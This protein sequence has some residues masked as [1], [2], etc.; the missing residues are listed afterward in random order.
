MFYTIWYEL[1]IVLVIIVIAF[2]LF[3]VFL[4]P[5]LPKLIKLIKPYCIKMWSVIYGNNFVL[6]C[7]FISVLILLIASFFAPNFITPYSLEHQLSSNLATT[8]NGLMSPLIAI[9]AAILTFM[10]F[11][12]QYN[13][14]QNIHKEN[15]K[16]Q[17]ERQFYEMLKIH[18]DNVDKM[19]F[20]YF[21]SEEEA[22]YYS[23]TIFN[24]L[25]MPKYFEK[26][27]NLIH[28]KGASA[29]R[30]FLN[31]FKFIYDTVKKNGSGSN[32]DNFKNAYSIFFYGIKINPVSSNS[33][34]V[35][36]N[37]PNFFG[38]IKIEKIIEA[39]NQVNSQRLEA[40]NLPRSSIMDGRKNVLNPYYRHLYFTVKSI[41]DSNFDEDE[42]KRYLKILRASL[43]AEE[44]VLL[45]FNWYYGKLMGKEKYGY[46]W[47][48]EKQK[49]FTEWYM[50]HNIVKNDFDFVVDLS[51]YGKIAH[52]LDEKID[53]N[54]CDVLSDLFEEYKK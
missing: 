7:A 6:E 53:E 47:Q 25:S 11:W 38:T 28:E 12:V 51:T 42:K 2:F 21:Y 22:K 16:Q 34:T 48:Y 43:T 36:P 14:N 44:Q 9:A 17:D 49:Y 8:V 20:V 1:L 23:Y 19:E 10:A 24:T 26:R 35:I 54:N 52:Q 13:A 15:K 3:H 29:I 45:L 4:F 46:K 18:R 32:I 27:F 39:K 5:C 50:I 31:E 30:Y 33:Y 37:F 40:Y 41:V